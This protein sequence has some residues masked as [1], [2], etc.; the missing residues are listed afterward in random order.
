MR[1]LWRRGRRGG[2]SGRCDLRGWDGMGDIL[3]SDS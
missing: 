3:S 1:G 2:R